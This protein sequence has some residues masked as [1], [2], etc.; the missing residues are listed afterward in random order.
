MK[1][2]APPGRA[3]YKVQFPRYRELLRDSRAHQPR[4]VRRQ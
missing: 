3:G 1:E 4:Q 2:I